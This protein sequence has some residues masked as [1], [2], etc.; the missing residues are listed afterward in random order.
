MLLSNRCVF[1]RARHQG[2]PGVPLQLNGLTAIAAHL[3]PS[4]L[5]Y[6][7]LGT[8]GMQRADL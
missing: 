8:V 7:G 6:F 4:S 1:G 3:R 2:H 5:H